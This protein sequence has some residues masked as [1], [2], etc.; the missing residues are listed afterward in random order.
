MSWLDQFLH[1]EKG[2]GERQGREHA[3]TD[4]GQAGQVPLCLRSLCGPGS[5]TS[6]LATSSSP[7]RRTPSRARSKARATSRHE[8]CSICRSS[9]RNAD[10]SPSRERRKATCSA[11]T[12]I[13]IK[14]R[15]PQ[16]VGTTALIPEFGGLVCTTQ[17][18]DAERA[19]AGTCQEDG[20]D[21]ERA[22]SSTARITLPYE[23]F[24]GTLGVEPGDRGG[25]VAAAG[26]LGRKHGPARMSRPAPSS[27][28]RSITRTPISISA[29]AT[30]RRA[31]ASCAAS[32]SR[33]HRRR[34]SRSTS[35]RT[36]R[37]PGRGSRTSTS[38]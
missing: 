28:F 4:R 1:G 30:P 24:I 21:R 22:S 12:S 13:R 3:S 7:R 17:H 23:P 5:D 33:S 20:G 38:S 35:S 14:P 34:P 19:T 36:G 25:D 16:P 29:T 27:I 9:I 37:S 2:R 32:P 31:T 18:G 6:N 11:S 26:L 8:S 10:R 15:G